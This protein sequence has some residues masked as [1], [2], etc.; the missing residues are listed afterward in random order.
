MTYSLGR[1]LAFL[2][3]LLQAG[4]ALLTA[5]GAFV[6][7]VAG[8]AGDAVFGLLELLVAA[9]LVGLGFG[10]VI[11]SR[12]LIRLT[13]IVEIALFLLSAPPALVGL[14]VSRDLAPLAVNLGLPL[15]VALLAGRLGRT[16]KLPSLG[17]S[18]APPPA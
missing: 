15:L 9:G 16:G 12:R 11:G 2:L 14:G 3:L 5:L 1:Q 10:F 18:P 6:G 7:A 4:I 13:L 17:T 8:F